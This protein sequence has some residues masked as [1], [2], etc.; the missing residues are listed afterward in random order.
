MNEY[1]NDQ[2]SSRQTEFLY[3][4]AH[5]IGIA[6]LMGSVLLVASYWNKVNYYVLMGWFM[7]AFFLTM[8]RFTIAQRFA[9]RDRYGDSSQWRRRFRFSMIAA[10]CLW[11]SI[12][13]YIMASLPTTDLNI[14]ILILC[15]LSIGSAIIN[16]TFLEMFLSFAIPSVLA[17]GLFLAVQLQS[18][19]FIVG[20]ILLCWF[21]L[22]YT[23]AHRFN[24]FISRQLRFE[25]EN[26]ELIQ[27][28]KAER[29]RVEYLR[30][31]LQLK[32]QIIGDNF[33][34]E[35]REKSH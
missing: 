16:A 8:Y 22:M 28:L 1:L 29:A 32:A 4:Q 13:I 17:P 2:V 26:I 15:G 25:A 21:T 9:K 19:S 18:D 5:N 6:G 23:T 30:D 34:K 31:E 27:E 35:T 11:G 10:G 20:V 24:K 7:I 12:A 33:D 14:L 3:S